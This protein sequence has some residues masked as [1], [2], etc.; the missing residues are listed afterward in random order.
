MTTAPLHLKEVWR[1]T[2][3]RCGWKRQV[4]A[5]GTRSTYTGGRG[6]ERRCHRIGVMQAHAA[7]I[8]CS[9]R[10]TQKRQEERLQ[11][12]GGQLRSGNQLNPGGNKWA[13]DAGAMTAHEKAPRGTTP[14]LCGLTNE[15]WPHTA[16]GGWPR[17]A[18]TARARR[19]TG[20]LCL[21]ASSPPLPPACTTPSA[22]PVA[23]ASRG[24]TSGQL[25]RTRTRATLVTSGMHR[26]PDG[27]RVPGRRR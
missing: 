24:F 5:A 20:D 14:S 12:H 21:W 22:S 27:A 7:V 4:R 2:A 9:S 17:A 10:R 11:Q 13:C 8:R 18:T 6:R 25:Q 15:P 3:G 19:Q 26:L 1:W 16:G 23:T